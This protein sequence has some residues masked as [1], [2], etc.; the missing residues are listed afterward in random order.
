MRPD[1]GRDRGG[2]GCTRDGTGRSSRDAACRRSVGRSPRPVGFGLI[3]G[4]IESGLLGSTVACALLGRDLFSFAL[5]S[6]G[7]VGSTLLRGGLLLRPLISRGLFAGALR[8]SSLLSCALIC[9]GLRLGLLR[10]GH[11]LR[12]LRRCQL[13]GA[14]L[15]LLRLLGLLGSFHVFS[16]PRVATVFLGL[17]DA[18]RGLS[19]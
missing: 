5:S 19:G 7:L 14:L 16:P 11:L 18:A 15:R 4:C 2:C 8:S 17:R 9:S 3:A 1:S 12:P 10:R 13:L 6:G